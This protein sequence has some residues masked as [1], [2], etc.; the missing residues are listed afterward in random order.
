MR[1]LLAA[2]Y[3][4]YIKQELNAMAGS[5][6]EFDYDKLREKLRTMSTRSPLYRLLKEE[7]GARGWWKDRA[8]WHPPKGVQPK[9]LKK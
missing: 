5:R 3:D 8:K 9:H 4:S 7:L 1:T 2:V 6:Q